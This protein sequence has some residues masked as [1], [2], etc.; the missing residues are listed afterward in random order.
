MSKDIREIIQLSTDY[1]QKHGMESPKV[2]AEWLI[3][4]ALKLE[5][6]QLY[7]QFDRPLNEAELTEIREL[8]RRRAA[9][10]PVQY[11]CGSA[12][13][14]GLDF[15]VGPGVLVP[16]PETERLVDLALH[17]TKEG[18]RLLDICTGSGCIPLTMQHER[19]NTLQVTGIELSPQALNYAKENADLLGSQNVTWLEGDLLTPLNTD[20]QF[21]VITSNPPYVA[22][23]ERPQMGKDVLAHEPVMALFAE[24]EGLQL[25][26]RLA[27]GVKKHLVD[28]GYFFMEFGAS[29]GP[30]IK[31]LFELHGYREVEIIQDYSHRDR[32]LK[33]RR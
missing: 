30:A 8:L 2:D 6:M 29:Q 10:E 12:C 23:S 32:I 18:D 25:I 20:Q 21:E 17:Q 7:L 22:E 16:R 27:Q 5:R 9:H 14:F 13:F 28:G 1:L 3:G 24:N 4:H 33:A 31:S 15:K 11:I 26:E 19:K